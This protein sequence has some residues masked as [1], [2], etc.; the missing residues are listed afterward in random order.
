MSQR[1]NVIIIGGGPTGASAAIVCRQA[2]LS[3]AIFEGRDF[4]RER[5]GEALPPGIELYFDTL[6][7]TRKI[8]AAGALR[9]TGNWMKWGD[10]CRFIP[11]GDDENG[12][13]RR[14]WQVPRTELDTILLE[15]A[16]QLGATVFQ[17]R[18]VRDIYRGPKRLA[19]VITDQGAFAA[20]F[21]IDAGGPRHWLAR[22]LG[23]PIQR[24]TPKLF[25]RYGWADGHCP[26]RQ[27][28]AL[29]QSDALGWTWTSRI[30]ENRY[31]W[32]RMTFEK[33][34]LGADWLPEEYRGM[35]PVGPG[36]GADFTWRRCVQSC[37]PGYFIAGDALAAT[38]P[39]IQQ[40]VYK[41]IVSGMKAALVIE[42]ILSR[43]LP[44]KEG[45]DQYRQWVDNLYLGDLPLLHGFYSRH[46]YAPEW[47]RDFRSSV[48]TAWATPARL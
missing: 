37:G 33:E 48:P 20:D 11:F 17:P 47:A 3:V 26:A 10:D 24:F 1:A 14:G 9:W 39:I 22:E 43:G 34:S 23:I 25:G 32:T 19:G 36:R 28:S 4:P 40:G 46:P 44:E 38:D 12:D 27:D 16:R 8:V 41:G 13:P 5:P 30:S 15:Q 29:Y 21:V 45:L 42:E 31:Q 7:V 2:G 18:I 35:T 6:E